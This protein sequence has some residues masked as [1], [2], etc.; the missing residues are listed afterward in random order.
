MGFML[1]NTFL[2]VGVL[3]ASLFAVLYVY[4]KLSFTYWKQRNVPYIKPTFLFGNFRDL[5]LFRKSQG[6]VFED[7][8]K[9]LDGEKCGGT[10]TFTKPTFIF[11]DPEII[12]NV[13]VKDFASF[14][15]RGFYVNEETEPLSGHLFF[16]CGNRWR[17]LR[18]K[19]TPTF[20]SGK[21]KMM[22][23]TL[24]ESGHE[25]GTILEETANNEEII[26]IKDTLARYSTD[27]ISSCAFGIQCNCLKNP[28]AE[29]RQWG[30]KVFQASVKSAIIGSL[31]GI[32]PFLV[33]VLKIRGLDPKVSKYFR[34]M[35]QD[36]VNYREK[37]NIKR[38]DFLQL[39]IQI[40]NEGKVEEE[41]S[42]PKQNGHGNKNRSGE[43]G[44]SM[45]SLAAQAF[46]FFLGGFETSSTTMT[47]CMY[48]LSLHQDIQERL[49]EE[50]DAVL[51]KHEGNITYEAIQE[52]KYLDKVVAETL[53]KYPVVPILN[54]ECTKAYKIPDTDIVLEKGIRTVIPIL[55]LHH[56][57]K[58]YPDPER[59][60]PER[61]S[62]EE[63]AKRHN[64][65][66]LPFGEGPRICIGMRFGLMQTKVGLVS[67]LSKYQFSVSKRTPVP[68]V[69]ETKSFNLSPVGGM[70]LQIK[71]RVK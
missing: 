26:E 45:N 69:F 32:F 62:E 60:D 18:A 35:V 21:M 33:N 31:L 37:D 41:H 13:L 51:K 23:Q 43:S 42:Y 24:V 48:E 20:T 47:F 29:F 55:G 39:L 40:K 38:N 64:Y 30:R 49:R 9:K 71:K 16:L 52:M 54:R 3:V 53:R 12:K 50:I 59:F 14:H 8:Y 65:V 27:V 34:S 6:H 4:F 46:A 17:N 7:L 57:P 44:F 19:L 25:L 36:T 70:W 2:D 68:L 28:D 22:F 15:D 58:Y 11:R 10:Y 61:F 56:D 5:I 66:Y 63:K 67:L 1:E